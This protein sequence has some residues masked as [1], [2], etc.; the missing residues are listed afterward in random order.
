MSSKNSIEVYEL[1]VCCNGQSEFEILVEV[2]GDAT[3]EVLRTSTSGED[4]SLVII[5]RA[6][7]EHGRK[8]CSGKGLLWSI[9]HT[10][11]FT[12]S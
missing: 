5:K 4:Y 8:N 7:K 12:C 11:L 9:S 3:V 6:K 2:F 1:D 10:R